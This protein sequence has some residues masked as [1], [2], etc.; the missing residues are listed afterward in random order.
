MGGEIGT[1]YKG[2]LEWREGKHD[3]GVLHKYWYPPIARDFYLHAEYVNATI[4]VSDGM[5]QDLSHILQNSFEKQGRK[6]PLG[7]VI[8]K[9]AIPFCEGIDTTEQQQKAR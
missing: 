5:L 1:A 7:A 6:T 3:D 8:D 4:D 2:L 9:K